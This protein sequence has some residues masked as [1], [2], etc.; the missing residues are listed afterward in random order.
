MQKLWKCT[1]LKDK[2]WKY[3][4]NSFTFGNVSGLCIGPVFG[5]YDYHTYFG[6]RAAKLTSFF[7]SITAHKAS[8]DQS[9]PTQTTL[10]A[11]FN[12]GGFFIPKQLDYKKV[13]ETDQGH[14][15]LTDQNADN[16]E[17]T[18]FEVKTKYRKLSHKRLG[19]MHT[20]ALVLDKN[21][22]IHQDS[23][24]DSSVNH[25]TKLT[26]NKET[27][28]R[29]SQSDKEDNIQKFLGV[30]A[31]ELMEPDNVDVLAVYEELEHR[32]AAIVR[33]RVGRG[34]AVLSCVHIE[35]DSSSL[36]GEN[37]YLKPVVNLMKPCD[38]DLQ[39]SLRKLLSYLKLDCCKSVNSKI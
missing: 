25:S 24:N 13:Y 16:E 10:H 9:A 19:E 27:E 39:F 31:L 17:N 33:C 34:Q 15:P 6:A 14:L 7:P 4:L 8:G 30:T 37:Q 3:L 11:Y 5:P 20:L 21:K 26:E 28:L 18:D 38:E 22:E 32:P 12:G 1:P 36:D 35:Y 2:L 29:Q 23:N